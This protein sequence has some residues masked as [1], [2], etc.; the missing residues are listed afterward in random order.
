MY[1]DLVLKLFIYECNWLEK[2]LKKNV[3]SLFNTVKN[4]T[5]F[6]TGLGTST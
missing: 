1:N 4:N 2:Y 3:L 6:K 5:N